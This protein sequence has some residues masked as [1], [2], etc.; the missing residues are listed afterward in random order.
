LGGEALGALPQLQLEVLA[1]G[2]AS[3]PLIDFPS[4]RHFKT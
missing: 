2:N 4:M 1:G 3:V